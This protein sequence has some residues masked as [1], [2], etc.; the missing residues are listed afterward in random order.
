MAYVGRAMPRDEDFRFLRGLGTYTD[1]VVA[2]GAAWAA[3]VRS[4]HAHARIRSIDGDAAAA[5]PGVLA[6]I[7]AAEW[8]AAGLGVMPCMSR[9]PFTDGR[10]MREAPR[11]VFAAGKTLYVGDALAAVIAETRHRAADGAEAVAVDYEPLPCVTDAAAA[12]DAGAPV[13]HERF[14]SN[15]VHEV[16]AG[17]AAATAAAF[18]RAAHVSE[19]AFRHGRVTANPMEP[20][21]YLGLYD[22]ARD[23]YTLWA[24]AQAPHLLRRWLAEHTLRVPIRKLRVVAPDV[25]GGFG[26][27][28]YHYPEQPAVLWAA[29]RVGRPVRWTASRSEAILSDTHARD[30][31]TRAAM[32]FD[33]EGSILAI[34][35]ETFAAYGAY[36][37]SFAPTI[38][39]GIYPLMMTGL[40]RIPAAHVKVTG[41]FTN[42]TPIDAYRGVEQA[43]AY[44]CERLVEKGARELGIEVAEIRRRNY[45]V[46]EDYPYTT[47]FGNAY[48]SGDPPGQQAMMETL[49]GYRALRAEQARL[50][51][52]GILMGIGLSG[53]VEGAGMGPSRAVAAA[54]VDIGG[55]EAAV[56]RVH[57]D[58]KVTLLV[59]THSHGQGHDI[60]FRQV[61]ADALGL[62]IA[63]I[64]LRQGD[65]DLGPG[66]FGTGAARSLSTAGMGLIEGSRRVI[67]KATRLAAHMIEC[68]EE[69][70]VYR[71][72]IFSI[73]GT[74]RRLGF[75]EV[76]EMAYYGADYPEEGFELGLEET[77]YYDPSHYNTPT[78]L[79]L[80][81]V[82]IDPETGVV[83]L[84][85]YY[86]VDD[87]GRIVNPLV[88][89]GQ[90]HGGIAQGVGQA[91]MERIVYD[92]GSGQ[93]LAGSFMDYA[94]PRADDL[95]GFVTAFQET[96]NP[97]N[98]LGVKGC[99][100]SG[101]SGPP[102]A[103][104][105]AIVDAL[106]DRGVRHLDMPYT[107]ERVWRALRSA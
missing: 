15:L 31:V 68:A 5:M 7:T 59:G 11:P 17:D 94:M 57:A 49:A 64:E 85:D 100:E 44:L 79:H 77:V 89:D 6:V 76:A 24:A 9:V 37:S 72:G 60:T 50:K 61:A 12:L 10:P 102:G 107:P 95:P 14:G 3:F 46:R 106:W 70:V 90:V 23:H 48:D 19:L 66:N 32:A 81:V 34:R 54:G 86:A 42:T 45:L 92:P 29:K 93:P 18:A 101:A 26:S 104:G 35:V 58:G 41:V 47:P 53:V 87:A 43:P 84:R 36:H 56:V 69:D 1:D 21:A 97:N 103:I 30:L 39:A 4:P 62:D 25:G 82:L 74:D 105:N 67:A 65:T 33:A 71:D 88:V 2:M 27:K 91:M 96:L 99:S 22:P 20:R 83:R 98:E 51:A 80:A 63:H 16:E 38:L 55:W 75:A 40:Y 73:P 13:L 28:F 52:D 8:E 78:A